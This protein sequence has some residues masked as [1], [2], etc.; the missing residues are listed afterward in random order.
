MKRFLSL[1]VVLM[2][3]AS[4]A[5]TGV[6]RLRGG[7][8]VATIN[9][10][11]RTVIGWGDYATVLAP[12]ATLTGTGNADFSVNSSSALVPAG[13]KGSGTATFT[14]SS[15]LLS[16][17]GL[18]FSIGLLTGDQSIYTNLAWTGTDQ[19]AAMFVGPCNN[20]GSDCAYKPTLGS[21]LWL[22]DG[23]WN[24][25]N[26][27]GYTGFKVN[28]Q[29]TGS[30]RITARS[31]HPDTALDANGNPRNMHGAKLGMMYWDPNG[32]TEA[33]PVDFRDVYHYTDAPSP[34]SATLFAVA[35][36]IGGINFYNGRVEAGP[37]VTDPRFLQGLK[38]IGTLTIDGYVFVNMGNSLLHSGGGL[39]IQNSYFEGPKG[40][41]IQTSGD[42]EL[43]SHNLAYQ[44]LGI[45]ADHP[46]FIQWAGD[47]SNHT[48]LVF[49]KNAA[50]YDT[51]TA[52][53]T[54]G[55]DGCLRVGDQS[56]PGILTGI[57]QNNNICFIGSSH[58]IAI[59]LADHPQAS[60]NTMLTD[61]SIK[62][63]ATRVNISTGFQNG[64]NGGIL[65]HDVSNSFDTSTQ[66]GVIT[67]SGNI[68][69]ATNS[70]YDATARTAAQLWATYQIALPNLDS[71]KSCP[72]W[73]SW[74]GVL[75]MF[76]PGDTA[77]ASGGFK[78]LDGTF[79]GALFPACLTQV[80]GAWN[81]GA[82]Y[83]CDA[84]WLIS[85]PAAT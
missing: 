36:G 58:G 68:S 52:P 9:F 43:F 16:S 67:G 56:A 1:L 19:V 14:R 40:D 7:A 60:F 3:C 24:T 26:V 61:P 21:T 74:A 51:V 48:D 42:H 33:Q 82:V 23:A 4:A 69:K 46:D 71:T 66:T 2:V 5:H 72:K 64:T 13:T 17:S 18:N 73:C 15:Y 8:Y 78:Q 30:G 50:V 62:S 83:A 70:N 39:T 38:P 59:P 28:S 81:D 6:L 45:T 41:A 53:D 77:V 75:F 12:G 80:N 79:S 29:Y 65:D 10:G 76:T 27:N 37:D 54:G 85:H 11:S 44:F 57:V 55:I 20:G 49:T 47:T 22:R 63:D 31:E 25:T 35:G 32:T 84:A 34:V